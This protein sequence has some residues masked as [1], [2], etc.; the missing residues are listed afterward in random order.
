MRRLPTLAAR[1]AS[2]RA[3]LA[4][5]LLLAVAT[6]GST[7]NPPRVTIQ[8]PREA[9]LIDDA[10]VSMSGRVARPLDEATGALFVN[11]VDLIDALGVVPPFADVAGVVMIGGEPIQVSEFH[12]VSAPQTAD[13]VSVRLTGLPPAFHLLELRAEDQAAAL[14]SASVAFAISAPL[15]LVLETWDAGG[16]RLGAQALP[17]GEA[18]T[19]SLGAAVAGGAIPLAGGDSLHEGLAASAAALGG[20][21]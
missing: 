10:S 2:S 12:W 20:N 11:G 16:R 1:R 9:Q 6:L 19:A 3:S 7:C 13:A 14:H 4:L 5:G 8:T 21:P 17:L 18:S 15:G